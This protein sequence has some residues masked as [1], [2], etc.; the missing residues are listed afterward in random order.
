MNTKEPG[1]FVDDVHIDQEAFI[2][3]SFGME[4]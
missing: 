1:S 3:G 2:D 4:N